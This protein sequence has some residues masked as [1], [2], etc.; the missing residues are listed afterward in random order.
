[1]LIVAAAIRIWNLSSNPPG[2]F[3]DEAAVGYNAYTLLHTL[4]DEHGKLLP[5]FFNTV[6][7]YKGPLEVYMVVPFVALFGLT[8]FAVRA[9][10][11]FFSML[12]ILVFYFLGKR[13]GGKAAALLLVFVFAFAPW[14]IHLSRTGFT[15]QQIY[16][17]FLTFSLYFFIRIFTHR[18]TSDV[19]LF[20]F[21][22]ALG[23]YSYFPA[24]VVFP[25]IFV[26]CMMLVRIRFKKLRRSSV[27]AG[28]VFI[29]A[30]FPLVLHTASGEGLSRWRQV[31]LGTK[32]VSVQK[33]I[34]SYLLHFSPEFLFIRGDA[35]LQPIV[36][37]S[38]KGAGQL[39]YWQALFIIVGVWYLWRKNRIFLSIIILLLLV[40]PLPS[41]L[42]S[43][44][45]PQATRAITGLVPFSLLSGIGVWEGYKILKRS[46]LWRTFFV[47]ILSGIMLFE[48][49]RFVL[50][51]SSYPSYAAGYWGW[52]YGF[53]KAL[54]R[55]GRYEQEY[56]TVFITNRFNYPDM[57]LQFYNVRT[58][59]RACRIMSNP[60]YIEKNKKWLYII[61]HDDLIDAKYLYPDLRF[62]TVET[63]YAPNN[64]AELFIGVFK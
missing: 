20:A 60:L 11:V 15:A 31:Q 56:E 49:S 59:C 3:V 13:I 6:G 21:I 39:Y 32:K 16:L 50:L 9:T 53:G 17:F 64:K 18:T 36:R 19:L 42:T 27:Y 44:A 24:R 34:R 28:I 54:N 12:T 26:V 63:I 62:K 46:V 37:H 40:Y 43:D 29:C 45:T 55:A 1:M 14:S 33:V 25:L 41:S 47:F 38:V 51:L 23:A 4:T 5:L 30:L 35:G 7:H 61:R 8:E 10:S 52:Q 22:N 58:A 48:L 2:F 57:L